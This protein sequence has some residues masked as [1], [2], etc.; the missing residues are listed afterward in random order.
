[1]SSQTQAAPIL[2][3]LVSVTATGEPSCYVAY[4]D[5]T[6]ITGARYTTNYVAREQDTFGLATATWAAI[7]SWIADGKPI[8]PVPALEL[9]IPDRISSRQFKL[10]LHSAGVFPQV[11][12]WISEQNT[13]TQ[14]AYANSRTFVRTDA[15]MQ[16]GFVA[17]GFNQQQIDEFYVSASLL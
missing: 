8:L 17:L 2:H 5:I 4:V 10:Q 16:V 3:E 9:A 6:D 15:M 14:I 12:A 13:A 11:E 1:M 7:A